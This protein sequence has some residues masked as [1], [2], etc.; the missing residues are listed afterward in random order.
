MPLTATVIQANAQGMGQSAEMRPFTG[1]GWLITEV[2]VEAP[3]GTDG[4]ILWYKS[5][6]LNKVTN[7]G[8]F[9]SE[10]FSPPLAVTDTEPITLRCAGVAGPGAVTVTLNYDQASVR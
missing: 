3:L 10:P 1:Q 8:E 9:T 5:G 7:I 6:L 4:A 2:A